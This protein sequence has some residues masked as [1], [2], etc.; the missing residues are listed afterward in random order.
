MVD[1][2]L[3]KNC[4]KIAY[5][6]AKKSYSNLTNKGVPEFSGDGMFSNILDYGSIKIGITS[7]GIGTKAEIAERLGKYD[8]LGYDLTAMVTDDLVCNG[9]IPAN[10]TNILDVDILDAKIVDD[11]MS[12]LYDASREAKIAVTGGEIA[13]LGFR[14]NGYGNSMHFN[15]CAT[16]IGYLPEGIEPITGSKAEVGDAIISLYHK[17]LRSNGYSLARSVLEKAFG[18][19]WHDKQYDS[20]NSWGDMLLHPSRIYCSAIT[21]LL[22]KKFDIRGIAHITGGSFRD[23]LGRVLK[24]SGYGATLNNLF[25]ADDFVLSL[26]E[27]GNIDDYTAY[28]QWNMSNGMM[29]ITKDDYAEDI[30]KVLAHLGFPAKI[31]GRIIKENIIEIDSK[32]FF[33]EKLKYQL[34]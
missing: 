34:D 26:Q 14:I 28:A 21:H 1:I 25:E 6:W 29:L 20:S 32:G 27:L 18:K 19:N 33:R 4:S 10:I 5:E 15:W 7:D 3:G 30:I 9:L 16:C 8:T 22:S 17:G 13:E 12:G 24:T 31:S 2:K 11:L 23:K